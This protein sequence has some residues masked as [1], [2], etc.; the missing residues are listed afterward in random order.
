[1]SNEKARKALHDHAIAS[2][3]ATDRA[4]PP[5]PERLRNSDLG[6]LRGFDPLHREAFL[7]L[8]VDKLQG[9]YLC[10]SVAIPETMLRGFV[11]FLEAMGGLMRSADRHAVRVLREN[12]P[13]DLDEQAKIDQYRK[14]F[15]HQVC[16]TF[17]ELIGQGMDKK[18]AIKATNR[19]LKDRE[20]PWANHETVRSTLSAAGHLRSRS[21]K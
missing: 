7:D 21:G 10:L 18:T 16:S 17:N 19:A 15:Q 5:F 13:L 6:S 8:R 12:K 4:T 3:A 2:R 20:H 9:D 11:V 14:D 1:M